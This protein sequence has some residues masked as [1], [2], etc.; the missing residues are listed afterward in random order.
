MFVRH[1]RFTLL[2]AIG[3][4]LATALLVVLLGTRSD[5]AGAQGIMSAPACQ[6]SATTSVPGMS[7]NVV[8]CVCGGMSC[9]VSEHTAQGR[10]TNLMQCVR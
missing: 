8:H 9:V 5:R 7:T 2:A 4:G 6:C 10:N 3:L 1:A